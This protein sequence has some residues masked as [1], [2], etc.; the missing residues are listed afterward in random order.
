MCYIKVITHALF[1]FSLATRSV[2]ASSP[3]CLFLEPHPHSYGLFPEACTMKRA[4]HAPGIFPLSGLRYPK[5][6]NQD[7]CHMKLLV[8]SVS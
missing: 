7:K 1:Y 6:G 4:Q 5:M 2:F 3:F 8:N